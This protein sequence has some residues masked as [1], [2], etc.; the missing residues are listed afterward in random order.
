[1][2]VMA[3]V[4]A[5]GSETLRPARG[6]SSVCAKHAVDFG[7]VS[8]AIR[9]VCPE[10]CHYI[11]IQPQCD[12][13]L[14]RPIQETTTGTG[15]LPNFGHIARIDL[16]VGEKCQRVDLR[17]LLPGEFFRSPLLNRLS[18]RVAWLSGR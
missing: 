17:L 6:P 13:L 9:N 11:G 12:L 7:L 18:F 2:A 16:V 5:A 3:V 14:H 10:P 15:P 4:E 1:M 8:P